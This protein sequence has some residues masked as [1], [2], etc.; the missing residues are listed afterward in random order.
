M[1]AECVG[2]KLKGVLRAEVP[3]RQPD[4][5]AAPWRASEAQGMTRQGCLSWPRPSV[6][7]WIFLSF[8]PTVLL[9]AGLLSFSRVLGSSCSA[10]GLCT[11]FPPFPPAGDGVLRAVRDGQHRPIRQTAPEPFLVSFTQHVC[12]CVPP[13][14]PLQMDC[15]ANILFGIRTRADTARKALIC[16]LAVQSVFSLDSVRR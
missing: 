5:R 15:D 13:P 10:F 8:Y 4:G 7:S 3:G 16:W 1:D 14:S 11:F 9:H 12:F 2:Q 6:R